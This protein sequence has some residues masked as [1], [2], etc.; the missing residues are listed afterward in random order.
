VPAASLSLVAWSCFVK[1]VQFIQLPTPQQMA[2]AR[3]LGM[4]LS[5]TPGIA[6]SIVRGAS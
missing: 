3:D 5:V 2:R 1:D 6:S 4:S